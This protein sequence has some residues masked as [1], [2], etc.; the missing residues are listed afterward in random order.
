MVQK[1]PIP[2]FLS[3]RILSHCTYCR[4][5][6]HLLQKTTITKQSCGHATFLPRTAGA[7]TSIRWHVPICRHTGTVLGSQSPESLDCCGPSCRLGRTAHPLV[8]SM[9]CFMTWLW[10]K[11]CRVSLHARTLFSTPVQTCTCACLPC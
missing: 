9:Q 10:A 11:W 3:Q 1:H 8:R 6:L 7:T 4:R 2:Q 5:P